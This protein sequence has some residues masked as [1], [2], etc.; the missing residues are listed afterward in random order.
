M[1]PKSSVTGVFGRGAFAWG[2]TGRRRSREGTDTPGT[3]SEGEGRGRRGAAASRRMPR[4][5]GSRQNLLEDRHAADRPSE[6]PEEPTLLTP[7]F[8]SFRLQNCERINFCG[9]K[10][11]SLRLFVT[12]ATGNSY[13]RHQ[14]GKP[15]SHRRVP[16]ASASLCPARLRMMGRAVP[17]VR[18]YS[19]AEFRSCF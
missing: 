10:P 4:I 9:R 14:R 12:A 6:P 17:S 15:R 11:S 16:P 3:R 8:Q 13:T 7:R 2:L 18:P 5:A 19:I 1:D